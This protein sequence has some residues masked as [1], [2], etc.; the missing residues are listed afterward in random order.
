MSTTDDATTDSTDSETEQEDSAEWRVGDVDTVQLS[1]LSYS[2][3]EL[4]YRS[5]SVE[6]SSVRHDDDDD[7]WEMRNTQSRTI[8]TFDPND[9]EVPDDVAAAFIALAHEI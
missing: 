3:Y 5:F 7:V 6:F 8:G 1:K 9:P 2:T 4:A